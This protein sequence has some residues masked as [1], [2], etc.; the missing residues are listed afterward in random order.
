[1][2]GGGT[3]WAQPPPLPPSDKAPI[4]I[5]AIH[6][7]APAAPRTLPLRSGEREKERGAVMNGSMTL[8][9]WPSTKQ[10]CPHRQGQANNPSMAV[11]L[12]RLLGYRPSVVLNL[13]LFSVVPPLL[14]T[15]KTVLQNSGVGRLMLPTSAPISYRSIARRALTRV[16]RR[17]AMPWTVLH[18]TVFV[19]RFSEGRE[20]YFSGERLLIRVYPGIHSKPVARRLFEPR[21]KDRYFWDI[22]HNFRSA[23]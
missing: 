21:S 1:M 20:R 9:R 11:V 5:A 16:L 17:R 2:A 19:S 18:C 4:A 3:N 6:T 22:N 12:G 8:A 7:I 15:R 13:G 14:C 23:K 10:S